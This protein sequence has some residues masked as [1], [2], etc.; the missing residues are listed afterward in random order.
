MCTRLGLLVYEL[1][2]GHRP[3]RLV[4]RTPEEIARV[5]CEQDPE[6]PSTVIAHVETSTREDGTTETITPATVSQTREGTIELL[7]QRLSGPLDDILLKALRKEPN[8]R[9]ASVAAFAEDLRRYISEQPVAVSWDRRRYRARR[10]LIRYRTA[11]A[12]AAL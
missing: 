4:K 9:Y 11:M 6:R 7:R 3:Y 5:V 8:E 2:T 10:L 12:V 1:V